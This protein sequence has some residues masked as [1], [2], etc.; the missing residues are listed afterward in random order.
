MMF[1]YS[2]KVNIC[3]WLTYGWCLRSLLQHLREGKYGGKPAGT[4]ILYLNCCSNNLR[5][6]GWRMEFNC[7]E[8]PSV[9]RISYSQK[10]LWF[11]LAANVT[12]FLTKSLSQLG[13]FCGP[14]PCQ[15]ELAD[16]IMHWE[17]TPCTTLSPCTYLLTDRCI[18][19]KHRVDSVVRWT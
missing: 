2:T 11:V 9:N 16:S 3:F 1:G 13:S 19:A 15:R 10:L 14:H 12:S 6:V 18:F 4:P 5:S 8:S 17:D 7:E